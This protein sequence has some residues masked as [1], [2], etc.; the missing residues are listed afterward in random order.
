MG[1]TFDVDPHK[2]APLG[3]RV[4]AIAFRDISIANL[5]KKND[6]CMNIIYN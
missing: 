6:L 5:Y 2:V 4:A 3:T 1:V